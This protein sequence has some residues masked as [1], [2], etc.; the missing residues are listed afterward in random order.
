MRVLERFTLLEVPER[1]AQRILQEV[2]GT[3]INGQSLRLEAART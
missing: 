2:N 1:Q 3:E